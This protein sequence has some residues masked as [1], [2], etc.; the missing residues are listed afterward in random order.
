MHIFII[1]LTLF[2]SFSA[3]QLQATSKTLPKGVWSLSFSQESGNVDKVGINPNGD[4]ETW[5]NKDLEDVVLNDLPFF[6][7]AVSGINLV[8]PNANINGNALL[9][10]SWDID[11]VH[12]DIAYGVTD[13]FMIF[14]NSAYNNSVIRFS[15]EFLAEAAK[16]EQE[17]ESRPEVFGRADFEVPGKTMAARYWDDIFIG[18]KHS[19]LPNM[20]FTARATFGEL[21]IGRDDKSAQKKDGLFELPTGRV[22]DQYEIYYNADFKIVNVQTR[23]MLGYILKT[24]GHQNF[25]DNE[26]LDINLGDTLLVGLGIDAPITKKFMSSWDLIYMSA[27]P[28]ERKNSTTGLFEEVPNSDV[29]QVLGKI[30]FTYTPLIFMQTFVNFSYPLYNERQGTIYDLPGRIETGLITEFGIR[31]FYK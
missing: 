6:G 24:E 30:N 11:V 22:H 4:E 10:D 28:D 29:E 23:M 9:A 18:F 19:F 3:T 13:K 14:A 26:N 5:T 17:I 15:D 16:M 7:N 1:A 21:K 31:L 2:I 25:F 27:S 20:A 8:S 12:I